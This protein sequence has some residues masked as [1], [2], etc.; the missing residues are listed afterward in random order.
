MLLVT[1]EGRTR[2]GR[3]MGAGREREESSGGLGSSNSILAY[4][5]RR[6]KYPGFISTCFLFDRAL[7]SLPRQS[8]TTIKEGGRGVGGSRGKRKS[9]VEERK[10]R[11]S[12]V[13]LARLVEEKTRGWK[14]GGEWAERDGKNGNDI[15]EHH[16]HQ[17]HQHHQHHHH[18]HHYQQHRQIAPEKF[19]HFV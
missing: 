6:K 7:Y 9:E 4:K 1:G 5:F 8:S 11:V 3:G 2:E 16:H 12:G 18:Q 14:C 15:G 10:H 13:A 17:H 19:G